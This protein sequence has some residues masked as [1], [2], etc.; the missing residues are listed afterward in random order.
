MDCGTHVLVAPEHHQLDPHPPLVDPNVHHAYAVAGWVRRNR[1]DQLL[2]HRA[3]R[4]GDRDA[5]R[6]AR[7]LCRLDD[8]GGDSCAIVDRGRDKTMDTSRCRCQMKH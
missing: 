7:G 3:N 4:D 2:S 8:P 6:L 5:D 1:A